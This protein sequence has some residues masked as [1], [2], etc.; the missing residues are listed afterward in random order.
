MTE[1]LSTR[2]SHCD[3][4]HNWQPHY[5]RTTQIY[6]IIVNSHLSTLF[7]HGR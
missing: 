4:P 5:K 7:N 3:E 6:I 2:L 1:P